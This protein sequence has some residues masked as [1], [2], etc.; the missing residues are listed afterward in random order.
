MYVPKEAEH[1]DLAKKFLVYLS[2]EENNMKF[3]KYTGSIKPFQY[4]AFEKYPE[5]SWSAYTKS[6]FNTFYED[7]T[8]Y[9]YNYP[10]NTAQENVSN[11]FIYRAMDF[12]G[13]TNVST[14]L[15]WLKE[16]DA[17]SIMESLKEN[18]DSNITNWAQYY[19]MEVVD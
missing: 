5:H 14:W 17:T 3:T 2:N 15:L 8:T 13:T 19:D 10:K 1:K 16:K 12:I 9:L 7:D 6:V 11:L 18:V 4:N